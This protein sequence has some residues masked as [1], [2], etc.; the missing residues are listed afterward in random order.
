M[1]KRDVAPSRVC[2][3]NGYSGAGIHRIEIASCDAFSKIKQI[4]RELVAWVLLPDENE[5]QDKRVE[6][7]SIPCLDA[8]SI[9]ASSTGY[10]ATSVAGVLAQLVERN[11]RNVEV[12]GS[13]PLCSTK[14]DVHRASFLYSNPQTF[15]FKI[16]I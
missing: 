1:P 16:K 3:L 13:T 10:D 6:S 11:V 12:R 14:I 7:I 9:P 4:S 15:H 8:G 2:G 5:G